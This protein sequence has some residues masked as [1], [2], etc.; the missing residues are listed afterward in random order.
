MGQGMQALGELGV[1]TQ[2][3]LDREYNVARDI[4][5]SSHWSKIVSMCFASLGY[6]GKRQQELSI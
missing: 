1:L 3:W 4:R 6:G 2:G 5:D